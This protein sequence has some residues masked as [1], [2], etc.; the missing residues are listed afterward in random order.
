M[1]RMNVIDAIN[2]EMR[3][4]SA[5]GILFSQAV[6][7]LIGISSRDLECLDLL[8]IYGPVTAGQLAEITNLTTGAVTGLVDRLEKASY[9][10][11]VPNPN[12][13]RSL[14]IEPVIE[15]IKR[16]IMPHFSSLD[17]SVK[18]EL[19]RYS[20]EELRFLLNFFTRSSGIIGEEIEIA[21]K[22]KNHYRSPKM[23]RITN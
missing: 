5:A 4:G 22:R 9:V 18:K 21:K 23:Y 6:A 10:R 17:Q 19:L 14:I 8:L 20:D 11:R 3:K 15:N 16:D 12:D 13:R 2:V 1:D 7:E